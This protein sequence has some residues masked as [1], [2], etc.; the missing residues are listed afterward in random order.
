[1]VGAHLDVSE[2]ETKGSLGRALWR[3]KDSYPSCDKLERR[4]FGGARREIYKPG[5]GLSV[6]WENSRREE[7]GLTWSKGP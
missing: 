4:R 1:M 2:R 7:V 6:Q 5:W 3:R